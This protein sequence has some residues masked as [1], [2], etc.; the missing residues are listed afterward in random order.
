MHHAVRNSLF[1][2]MVIAIPLVIWTTMLPAISLF[3]P[4]YAGSLA[5]SISPAVHADFNG[6][7]IDDLAVGV[8]GESIGN[9]SRAGAVNVIYGSSSRG[10]TYANNQ[11][12]HQNVPA[13]MDQSEPDDSFGAFT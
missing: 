11:I 9:I 7:G 3:Q 8:P 5:G 4:V 12:W 1:L 2:K 13:I 10:L 6:D